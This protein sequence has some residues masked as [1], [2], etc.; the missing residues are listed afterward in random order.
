MHLAALPVLADHA[1]ASG[2]RVAEGAITPS[3][4]VALAGLIEAQRR[5]IG[6]EAPLAPAVQL[7]VRFVAPGGQPV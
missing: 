4:A 7:R 2:A 1:G 3:E 6:L 5:A